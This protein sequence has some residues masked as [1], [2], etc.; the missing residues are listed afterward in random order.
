MIP[1]SL[2]FYLQNRSAGQQGQGSWIANRWCYCYHKILTA[3]RSIQGHRWKRDIQGC[4]TSA[5]V[6]QLGCF[7]G[8]FLYLPFKETNSITYRMLWSFEVLTAVRFKRFLEMGFQYMNRLSSTQEIKTRAVGTLWECEYLG[9]ALGRGCWQTRLLH[10]RIATSRSCSWYYAKLRSP[11]KKIHLRMSEFP[12]DLDFFIPCDDINYGNHTKI[13]ESSSL[14]V[15]SR[16]LCWNP[17]RWRRS[18]F[19]A[20]SFI[21]FYC[22]FFQVQA[23]W[24]NP[25]ISHW[26]IIWMDCRSKGY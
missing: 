21:S 2:S 20:D 17:T 18:H 19:L 13:R 9:D 8:N 3:G 24:S 5:N 11:S 25:T 16:T 23:F 12:V 26:R 1:Q 7:L 14:V 15:S 22:A 10:F 4:T 6:S